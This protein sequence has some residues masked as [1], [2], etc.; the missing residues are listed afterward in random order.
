MGTEKEKKSPQKCTGIYFGMLDFWRENSFQTNRDGQHDD[1]LVCKYCISRTP[2]EK[3]VTERL[4]K[5]LFFN[6]LPAFF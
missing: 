2:L 3:L 6:K 4:I 1:V 5:K